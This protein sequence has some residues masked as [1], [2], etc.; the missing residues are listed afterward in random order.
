M[1]IR[2]NTGNPY[3]NS[4]F[5]RK[6]YFHTLAG[7]IDNPIDFFKNLKKKKMNLKNEYFLRD[8]KVLSEFC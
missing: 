3:E 8:F 1:P 5:Q 2:I 6:N 7:N 4:N